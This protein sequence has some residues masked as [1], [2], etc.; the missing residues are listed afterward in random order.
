MFNDLRKSQK[1][2]LFLVFLQLSVWTAMFL[3]GCGGNE[4]IPPADNLD[5]GQVTLMW[6]DD[7]GSVAYNIYGSKS[8][9]VTVF[10]S[11]KISHVTNPFTIT[12]LEPGATYYFVVTAEDGSGRIWKSKE[13]SFTVKRKK[14]LIQF[15]DIISRSVPNTKVSNSEQKDKATGADTRD[16]TLSW[17]D[18]P[19][20]TSYNIYWS[21]RPGVTKK[22]GTKISNVKSP[23]KITGLKRGGKYYFVVTA[24]HDSAESKESKEI[25]YFVGP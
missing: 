1:P 8:P 19:N 22:N 12:N 20:A 16:V 14:G 24:V 13:I 18:V 2:L 17:K 9:G 23:H 4:N 7:P 6:K 25:S 3:A 11:Y 10:N 21:D 15:G 5:S